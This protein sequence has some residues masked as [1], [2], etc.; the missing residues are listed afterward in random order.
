MRKT[1]LMSGCGVEML[2]GRRL[3]SVGFLLSTNNQLLQ[4]NTASPREVATPIAISGLQDGEEVVAIDMRPATGGLYGVGS[5]SQLYTIDTATGAATAVGGVFDVPLSGDSFDMDFNPVVDRIRLVSNTDQNMRINPNTGAVVDGDTG[6]GGVQGDT[7][8]AFDAGDSNAAA[9]PVVGGVAYTNNFSGATTTT[10]LAIDS[11]LNSLLRQGSVDGTP[12]SPNAGTLFTVGSIKIDAVKRV[13]FDIESINGIDTGFAVLQVSGTSLQTLY[14]INLQTGVGA[15]LGRISTG[16][17]IADIAVAPAAVGILAV[18]TANELVGFS[19][20]NPTIRKTVKI[21]GLQD[22]EK[23]IGLDYRPADDG[24]YGV[25]DGD[26]LYVINPS[27]GQAAQVLAPSQLPGDVFAQSLAGDS[28]GVDFNPVPDRIR[29]TSNAQQNLRVNPDTGAVVD[30]DLIVSGTQGDTD[31]VYDLGDTNASAEPLV[32][33]SAYTN[34]FAGST[35]TTL[36]GIDSNLNVLVRQGSVDGTP[37]SPNTGTLFT[38][39]ALG[40]DVVKR[41]GFDISSLNGINRGLA[42]MQV[43]GTS[44]TGLYDINLNTGAATRISDVGDGKLFSAMAIR[45]G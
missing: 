31:L 4:F 16:A 10:L 1:K 32:V 44:V 26:R 14:S 25:T 21:K 22:G 36:F 27:N 17:R 13:G 15:V 37:V 45:P 43:D 24:L 5:T 40:A 23:I 18:S 6:T 9:D 2:E 11:S 3:L 28:F 35:T 39:G 30:T 8:L 20:D 38:I 34:S 29:I 7:V 41:V 42:L 12:T 19:S 33:G